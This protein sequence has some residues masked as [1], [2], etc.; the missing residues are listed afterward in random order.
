MT[1]IKSF[2]DGNSTVNQR[3]VAW[4]SYLKRQNVHW[5]INK[6]IDSR[7]YGMMCAA[8]SCRLAPDLLNAYYS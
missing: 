2:M 3:I 8:K 1:G 4:W 5:W 7:G 6:L